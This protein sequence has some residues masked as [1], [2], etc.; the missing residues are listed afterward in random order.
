MDP[1]DVVSYPE[2]GVAAWMVALSSW[3]S[4]TA[5]FG[6]VNSVGVPEA[7]VLT[8]ILTSSSTDTTGWIFGIYALSLTFAKIGPV[9]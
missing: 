6:V 1:V 2:G 3:C 8:N 7:Y 4:M 9:F 5:G